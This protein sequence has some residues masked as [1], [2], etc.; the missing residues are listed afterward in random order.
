VW[1]SEKRVRG[2]KV[3]ELIMQ[4]MQ[5][6]KDNQGIRMEKKEERVSPIY[7]SAEHIFMWFIYLNLSYQ[8]KKKMSYTTI[9]CLFTY[10]LCTD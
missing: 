8:M 4:D 2:G 10:S 9:F 6:T 5:L 7:T 1:V 3:S